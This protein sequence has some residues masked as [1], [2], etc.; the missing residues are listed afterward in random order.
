[1]CFAA[2]GTVDNNEPVAVLLPFSSATNKSRMS[3]IHHTAIPTKEAALESTR[4]LA[5]LES[6]DPVTILLFSFHHA[7]AKYANKIE[8]IDSETLYFRLKEG[9]CVP[10]RV[11][12]ARWLLF[13]QALSLFYVYLSVSNP[14]R[15]TLILINDG[16]ANLFSFQ[17]APNNAFMVGFVLNISTAARASFG[18]S[19]TKSLGLTVPDLT[20]NPSILLGRSGLPDYL[21]VHHSKLLPFRGGECCLR[22]RDASITLSHFNR[23]ELKLAAAL[24]IFFG[25]QISII[26]NLEIVKGFL[27]FPYLQSSEA[28]FPIFLRGKVVSRIL[29]IMQSLTYNGY[30]S[31][32]LREQ[33]CL[34]IS[35]SLHN[36][37]KF[38]DS[39]LIHPIFQSR[40][41]FLVADDPSLT[42]SKNKLLQ[43]IGRTILDI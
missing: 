42:A 27:S 10:R 16:C 30:T 19:N 22:R 26:Q 23:E 33:P 11:S 39:L 3:Q 17:E 29:V 31:P 34:I 15:P 6:S 36:Q 25:T 21:V 2:R 24:K 40:R 28:G 14:K 43:G 4:N 9:G 5:A 41:V 38:S 13:E 7:L 18:R 32:G 8:G 37:A 12:Q 1:M 35:S 20:L